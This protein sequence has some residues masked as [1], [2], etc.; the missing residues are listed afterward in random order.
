VAPRVSVVV[1]AYNREHYLGQTIESVLAQTFEDWELI[2]YDD[3]S[4]DG[5]RAVAMSYAETDRRIRVGHGP[6]SGVAAARNRGFELTNADAQFVIFL[7]SDDLWEPDALATLA[8]VLDAYP[9]YVGSHCLARCIDDEGR[10]LPGDD[11]EERSGDRH[12]FRS[13]RLVRLRPDEPTTFGDLV[14]HNWVVTP[15]T[16]LIRREIVALVGGFDPAVDP[17]DDADL[18]IR[19]SRH[20]DMGFV[21]RPLLLWRKHPQT[22]TN[23][24]PRWRVASL[25]VRAKTLT[26]L[27]NT[28]AQRQAMRLAY[29]HAVGSLWRDGRAAAANHAY[30]EASRQLLKAIDVYQAYL[31]ATVRAL[32]R[33]TLRA[34]QST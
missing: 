30:R 25:R 12:G 16:Q 29:L 6:N 19:I 15:G 9:A 20:G 27:S 33:R 11:L 21:D 23:T 1:P 4:T 14:Y 22:L 13:G 10:P 7:D 18:S 2:V 26:D 32:A 31:R 8:R 28:P 34:L 24:S 5:T 17:A 3:G